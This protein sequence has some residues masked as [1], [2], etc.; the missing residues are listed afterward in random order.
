MAANKSSTCSELLPMISVGEGPMTSVYSFS[1]K[2]ALT[3]LAQIMVAMMAALTAWRK[4]RLGAPNEP[5]QQQ[6]QIGASSPPPQGSG[7]GGE[8]GRPSYGYHSPCTTW[9][10]RLLHV[11]GLLVILPMVAA[12]R[13]LPGRRH[14][15]YNQS[16]F[17][18]TN[19]AVL[20][21]LGFAFMA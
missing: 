10:F 9:H 13:L 21:A 6:N 16:V 2:E 5:A 1:A 11:T 7:S 20:T 4:R 14:G 3:A 15:R 19:D 17:V 8:L 12:T 18:E